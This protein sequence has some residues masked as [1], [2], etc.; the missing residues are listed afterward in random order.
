[1]NSLEN[2][3]IAALKFVEDDRIFLIELLENLNSFSREA[4]PSLYGAIE[5]RNIDEIKK[6][7]HSIKG[8]LRNLRAASAAKNAEALEH[9]ASTQEADFILLQDTLVKLEKG[10]R[11][12]YEYSMG[13]LKN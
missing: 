13:R 2:E 1:M 9:A 12:F 4:L 11:D 3:F 7:S 6:I 5:A 8:A 10:I